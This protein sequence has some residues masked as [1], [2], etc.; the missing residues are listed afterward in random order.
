MAQFYEAL[1]PELRDFIEAQ[2]VFFTATAPNSGRINVSPKGMDTF[3]IL[4]DRTV[5][6]LDLT[7][8]GNE[9]SA[10]MRENGRIT[11]MFCSFGTT[12][13]IVRLHGHGRVL[14][15]NDSEWNEL[16]VTFP[17]RE[18]LDYRRPRRTRVLRANHAVSS[19]S[20]RSLAARRFIITTVSASLISGL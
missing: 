15:S 5:A 1:T 11:V 18:N 20:L 9:T 19:D 12:P 10:H 7:G 2:P 16:H 3:R 4:D 8:S 6:Y 14:P 13:M 17:P